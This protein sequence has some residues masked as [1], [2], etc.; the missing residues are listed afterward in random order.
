MC[1]YITIFT[2][3]NDTEMSEYICK[4]HVRLISL[5]IV[6]KTHGGQY[7]F[8]LCFDYLFT[9]GDY[10]ETNP[11]HACGNLMHE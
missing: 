11:Y 1:N 3:L 9:T 2:M 7:H 4:P 6:F 8:N 5:T 10:G